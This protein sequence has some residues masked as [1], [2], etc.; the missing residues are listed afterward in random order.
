MDGVVAYNCRAPMQPVAPH[1]DFYCHVF[2][3]EAGLDTMRTGQG[4][5]PVGTV[6]V[7]QKFADDQGTETELFTVM[8]KMADGYDSENGNWEY[9]TVDRSAKNVLSRG[10]LESCINCHNAYE[11]TDYV[12]REYLR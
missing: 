4:Q 3:N 10:R 2:V 7:K 9:S 6:I 5:Y 12:T 11:K 8:R 1:G